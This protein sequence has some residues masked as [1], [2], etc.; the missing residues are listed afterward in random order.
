MYNSLSTKTTLQLK[1]RDYVTFRNSA[2]TLYHSRAIN[3]LQTNADS[4]LL[5]EIRRIIN[6]TLTH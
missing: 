3:H 4:R 5:Y 2:T 1:Q 6:K